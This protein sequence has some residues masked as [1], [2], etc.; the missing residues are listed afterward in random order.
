MNEQDQYT[1]SLTP[2]LNEYGQP[3]TVVN[4]TSPEVKP[5]ETISNTA[6]V[7]RKCQEEVLARLLKTPDCLGRSQLWK[8]NAIKEDLAIHRETAAM[9]W[10]VKEVVALAEK[11]L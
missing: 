9:D 8:V 1:V 5:V 3:T 4:Q 6:E 11:Y 2:W 7:Y 10:F